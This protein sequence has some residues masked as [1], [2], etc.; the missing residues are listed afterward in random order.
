[1]SRILLLHLRDHL[2]RHEK[3][4]GHIG[5]HYSIV[6][7]LGVLSERLGNENPCVVNQ[8]IDTAEMLDCRFR[9]V[10]GGFLLAAV[11]VDED[12]IGRRFKLFRLADRPRSS[13]NG[14][15]VFDKCQRDSEAN[16]TGSTRYNCDRLLY[17]VHTIV[18]LIATSFFTG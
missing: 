17:A 7:F 16:S 11:T 13:H 14:V 5:V 9:Y 12:E 2:L 6:V 10:D 1:M 15:A 3:E 18:F 4:T 8:Q